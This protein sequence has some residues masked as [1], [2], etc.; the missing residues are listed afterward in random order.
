VSYVDYSISKKEVL[1]GA[2]NRMLK[3]KL[4]SA[5]Q[6]WEEY[7]E[8]RLASK[9]TVGANLSST[10]YIADDRWICHGL[11]RLVD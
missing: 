1:Q 4:S 5:W 9:A 11:G 2:V 10:C 3:V 7:V 8:E 6:R